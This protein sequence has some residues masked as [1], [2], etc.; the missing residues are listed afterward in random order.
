MPNA[1]RPAVKDDNFDRAEIDNE[2][3]AINRE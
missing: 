3:K 2:S 1:E